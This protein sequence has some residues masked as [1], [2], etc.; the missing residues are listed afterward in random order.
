MYRIRQH[1]SQLSHKALVFLIETLPIST[2]LIIFGGAVVVFAAAYTHLTPIGHGI[3]QNLTPIPDVTFWTGIYFSIVTISSLGFGDMHPMGASKFLVSAEVLIGLAVMG[4]VIAKAT[5]RR[6]SYHVSRLFSSDAQKRLEQIA[7]RVEAVKVDLGGIMPRLAAVYQ[8]VPRL[9]QGSTDGDSEEHENTA[10]TAT[11]SENELIG[12]FRRM[13]EVLSSNCV[14]LRDYVR[15]EC[16][17]GDFFQS[18]PADALRR[19]GTAVD[20]AYFTLAQLIVTLPAEA[21][22]NILDT[23]CRQ[24]ISESIGS[25]ESVCELVL[26]HSK[27]S[28]ITTLFSQVRETCKRVPASYYET[29]ADLPPDQVVVEGE[30][31]QE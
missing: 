31:P 23:R 11:E 21:R 1:I 19:V 17:M 6:L 26:K 29:P 22:L 28:D 30:E 16:Q 4:I 18:A 20:G 9:E 15:F 10:R 24:Q 14:G 27:S 7:E 12:E 8:S 5:S 3:G 2:Y 13:L 25:Q